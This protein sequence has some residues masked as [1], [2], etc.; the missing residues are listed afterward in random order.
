MDESKQLERIDV[1]TERALEDIKHRQ[2]HPELYRPIPSN[3]EDLDELIG[4]FLEADYVVIGGKHKV[5]KSSLLLHIAMAIA[6]SGRGRVDYYSLEEMKRQM[7]IRAL[8]R[9]TVATNR[10]MIRNLTLQPHNI[11]ELEDAHKTIADANIDLWVADNIFT[12]E[13]MIERAIADGST[14]RF[15]AIDYLQLMMIKKDAEKE[16]QKWDKISAMM[17]RAR[18]EYGLG[19]LMTYQIGDNDKAYGTR[20]VYKDA[21]LLMEVERDIDKITEIEKKESVRVNI[22][23]SRICGSGKCELGF[24]GPH[25]RVH[26]YV[27]PPNTLLKPILF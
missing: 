25:S 2:E 22:L 5:G 17:I 9:Q 15:I 6:T 19:I 12:P 13:E 16:Y 14:T 7:A 24:D 1:L 23:R 18:N 4:G 10:T 8:S 26:N 20:S 27:P 3:L 21:D 11:K